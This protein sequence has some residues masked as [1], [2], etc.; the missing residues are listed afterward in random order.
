MAREVDAWCAATSSPSVLFQ[1]TAASWSK[2]S[3]AERLAEALVVL[4]VHLAAGE[5]HAVGADRRVASWPA[6]PRAAVAVER[7]RVDVPEAGRGQGGEYERVRA[8]ARWHAFAAAHARRRSGGRRLGGSAPR[9]TGRRPRG[10]CRTPPAA[11]R[12]ARCPLTTRGGRAGRR[13][14]RATGPGERSIRRSAAVIG[15]GRTRARSRAP[16]SQPAGRVEPARVSDWRGEGRLAHQPRFTRPAACR[17]AC[18]RG[19]SGSAVRCAIPH[20]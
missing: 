17:S 14:P 18:W 2:H 10:G 7:T 11:H 6:A 1:I 9:R 12:Q 5:P 3:A 13:S 16:R 4:G 19:S 15:S 8:D 20:R